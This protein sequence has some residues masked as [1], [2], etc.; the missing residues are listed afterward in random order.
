MLDLVEELVNLILAQVGWT[1]MP[2][3]DG[4][5]DERGVPPPRRPDGPVGVRWPSTPSEGGATWRRRL[6]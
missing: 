6:W 5:V 4:R 3:V 1:S 2:Q